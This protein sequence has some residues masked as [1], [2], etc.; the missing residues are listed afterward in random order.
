MTN[1]TI[2]S[3]TTPTFL[4]KGAAFRPLL[5]MYFLNLN[6]NGTHGPVPNVINYVIRVRLA[7]E[8]VLQSLR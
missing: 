7:A 4:P 2:T 8:E 5:L 1:V 3:S 6:S